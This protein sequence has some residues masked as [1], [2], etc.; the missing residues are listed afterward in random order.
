MLGMI[1]PEERLSNV[2][3][4]GLLAVYLWFTVGVLL[5]RITKSKTV[6]FANGKINRRRFHLRDMFIFIA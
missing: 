1:S 4:V 3:S 5:L 6:R 2:V